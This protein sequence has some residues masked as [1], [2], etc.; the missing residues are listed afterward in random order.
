MQENTLRNSFLQKANPESQ[1]SCTD[2]RPK[3]LLEKTIKVE[4]LEIPTGSA[5]SMSSN[6]EQPSTSLGVKQFIKG[7]SYISIFL[8]LF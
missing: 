6:P 5:S 3:T 7:D 1:S 2:I 8:L 4:P